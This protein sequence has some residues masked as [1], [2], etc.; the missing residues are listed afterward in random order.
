MLV[1]LYSEQVRRLVDEHKK[2]KRN[3]Q[4]LFAG[5]YDR[6][7]QQ[8][9]VNLFEVYADFPDPGLGKLETFMFP[10]SAEFPMKPGG[11]LRLTIT[12]PSEL[13]EAASRK[14][15]T[16]ASILDSSD[17]EVV[18]PKGANWRDTIEELLK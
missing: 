13:H 15:A 16:L 14:D 17:T 12:S 5:W 18:Y 1:D 11:S 4:L 8:G 2:I 10:S 3:G 6:D 9:D 7:N